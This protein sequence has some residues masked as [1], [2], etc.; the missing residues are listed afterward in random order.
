MRLARIHV[1]D[2][3]ASGQ[4]LVLAGDAG[5]HLAR[6]LRCRV[7]D[8]LLLFNGSGGEYCAR[9]A[10]VQRDQVSVAV[11][12]FL[13]VDRESPLAIHLGLGISRGER[14]DWAIQKATELGAGRITP[15]VTDRVQGWRGNRSGDNKLAHWRRIVTSA[16]EQSG[17]TAV[18]T[19]DPPL[20]LADWLPTVTASAKLL[21]APGVPPL[22]LA[23]SAVASVALLVG[24]EGGLGE[25][26]LELAQHYGFR[27]LALGP[28][29]LR[30]ETAPLVAIALCQAWWGDLP[31]GG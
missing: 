20:E 9:I 31:R 4:L 12:E 26:E 6:V 25:G 24:A 27:G 11:G 5:H 2:T 30:T 22:A 1:T 18:P 21:L 29:V 8:E 23:T 10:A 7:G 14:M 15:L 19:V 3:L 28:R 16:C 13:D 17:R